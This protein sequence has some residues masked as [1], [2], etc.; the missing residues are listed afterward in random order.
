MILGAYSL[1]GIQ[2]FAAGRTGNFRKGLIQNVAVR[3][4]HPVDQVWID[5][6]AAIGKNRIDPGHLQWVGITA[7]Q[8]QGQ[9]SGQLFRFQSKTLGS[10]NDS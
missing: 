5:E 4:F 10:G 8:C 1:P 2:V 9:T 3:G 6:K 7:A